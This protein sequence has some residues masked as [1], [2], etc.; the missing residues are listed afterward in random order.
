MG[1]PANCDDQENNTHSFLAKTGDN[2][3]VHV[4][5]DVYFEGEGSNFTIWY[6]EP[7]DEP[8]PA[9]MTEEPLPIASISNSSMPESESG[10]TR[11]HG[12]STALYSV[13]VLPLL[14]SLF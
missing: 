11:R 1:Q 6:T 8:T 7:T 12:F 4:R 10:S 5:S 3:Y 14:I 13:L 2:Y 9:P